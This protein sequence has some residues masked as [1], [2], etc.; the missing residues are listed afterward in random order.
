M[1]SLSDG[2]S[3]GPPDSESQESRRLA[4]TQLHRQGFPGKYAVDVG[5][6]IRRGGHEFDGFVYADRRAAAG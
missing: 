2:L 4:L 6:T 3:L 1:Y 5:M